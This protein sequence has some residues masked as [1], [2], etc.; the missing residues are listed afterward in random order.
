MKKFILAFALLASLS[1][2]LVSCSTDD[3]DLQT[4][5]SNETTQ[6]D[7]GEIKTRPKTPQ[8]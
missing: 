5:A 4:S 8:P 3:S 7:G 6:L 2:T 1:S